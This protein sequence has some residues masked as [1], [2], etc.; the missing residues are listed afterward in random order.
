M[1]PIRCEWARGDPLLQRY[2]DEE[3]GVPLHDDQRLF[4]M[5]ILEGFQAGLSW[6]TV[7]RKRDAFRR[8]FGG[9]EPAR[10]AALDDDDIAR[11]TQDPGIVR[12]RAKIRS[13]VTNAEAFL[14]VR[15][16]EGSFDAYLWRF[17]GGAPIVRYP[18]SAAEVPATSPESHELSRDLKRRGFAFVGP[19]IVYAFMQATGVVMDHTVSC[20][21]H[22]ELAGGG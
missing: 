12:N 17:V 6:L 9:F 14:R 8:A 15:R 7:L 1:S 19:T 18:A 16:Q 21:R 10:V 5:L 2:H 13:A 22:R 4:E 20:Y 3:W 11:L